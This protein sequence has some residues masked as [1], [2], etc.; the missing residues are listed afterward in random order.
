MSEDTHPGMETQLRRGC[1]KILTQEVETQLRRG[2]SEDTH[3]G[4][5]TTLNRWTSQDTHP[6]RRHSC[7]EG[8]GDTAKDMVVPKILY[9]GWRK[10]RRG[11]VCSRTLTQGRRHS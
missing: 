2:V 11:E 6:G 9:Q 10:A 7:G 3:P 5:E 8:G 4:V 1:L